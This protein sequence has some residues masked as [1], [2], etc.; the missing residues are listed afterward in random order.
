M[1]GK[2]GLW[3]A[4]SSQQALRRSTT[5]RPSSDDSGS[6]GRYGILSPLRIRLTASV[7]EGESKISQCMQ[8]YFLIE[9]YDDTV[10]FREYTRYMLII[11]ISTTL[12]K[13]MNEKE[14]DSCQ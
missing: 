1:D 5:G 14:V 6:L 9:I 10:V 11:N 2:V 3:S 4:T 7:V 12:R 13:L 8:C